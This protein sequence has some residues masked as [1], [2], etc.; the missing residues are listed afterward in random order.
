[1]GQPGRIQILSFIT[2]SIGNKSE[3]GE[4]KHLSTS[5]NRKHSLSS[6]ERNGKSPNPSRVIAGRRF[7]TG[8][9]RRGG[10]SADP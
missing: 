9:V 6:G 10:G 8:V 1:M 4:V 2:E 7:G 3:R 5:R